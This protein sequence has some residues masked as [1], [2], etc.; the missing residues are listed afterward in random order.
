MMEP[1]QPAT[2]VEGMEI[3]L[4]SSAANAEHVATEV[5]TAPFEEFWRRDR[6]AVGRALA[7][8][9]GDV[10]L[11]AEATDEAMA[12]AFQ[13]WGRVSTLDSPAGWAYR[14]G[15]NWSR[16]VLRR[17]HRT[18][19]VWMAGGGEHHDEYG[20]DPAV[21]AAVAE[22]PATQR[23]VVVCRLLLGL[24]EAQ[25]AE[26]W[27]LRPGTVKSRLSRA[28]DHLSTSLSHLDPKEPQP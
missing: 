6:V 3:A 9:L 15:L 14:V 17:L 11:A 25:T 23:A 1:D 4:Q 12:R 24:S 28:V 13:H 20:L 8:T 16:S 5:T 26:A 10:Q 21:T 27:K 18:P 7:V 19:P 2:G 22:L